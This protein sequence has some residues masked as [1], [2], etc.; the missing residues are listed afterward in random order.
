VVDRVLPM[1]EIARAHA[2]MERDETFGKIVL[3]P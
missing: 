2:A 1:S 3:R